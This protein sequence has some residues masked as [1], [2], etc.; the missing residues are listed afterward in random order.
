MPDNIIKCE[1]NRD[2][3]QSFHMLATPQNKKL[4]YYATSAGRETI[5]NGYMM[6]R[7]GINVYMIN[8]V[9]SGHGR[10]SC[11]GE[12]YELKTGDLT[13]LHLE[14]RSALSFDADTEI[15]YFHVQGGQTVDMYDAFLQKGGFVLGGV[16]REFAEKCFDDFAAAVDTDDGFYAQS[17]IIHG[18]LNE[19]LRVRNYEVRKKCPPLVDDIMVHIMYSTPLPSQNEVAK[20]FGFSPVYIE[21]VFK[22]A[23]GES[24]SAFILRHKYEVACRLLADTDVS[25]C[26]AARR[27]GYADSK[28]L[29]A[30][31]A[32]HG[33]TPLAYRK[34][35]R[36]RNKAE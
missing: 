2:K 7:S 12:E 27:V 18:L 33:T 23:T 29:I 15:V 3:T 34:K 21:R 13:F 17:H 11:D 30:L 5:A 32:K 8:Y 35:L 9:A 31:F 6:D 10:L 4:F 28:G 1:V 14:K 25:V 26:E 24:M 36:E 22:K 16:E 19:I 20:R